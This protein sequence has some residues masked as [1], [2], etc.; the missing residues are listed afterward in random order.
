MVVAAAVDDT[1]TS[2]APGVLV[3]TPGAVITVEEELP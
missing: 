1:L 3:V 2:H